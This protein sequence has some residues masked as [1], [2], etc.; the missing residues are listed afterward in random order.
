MLATA[1]ERFTEVITELRSIKQDM[2]NDSDRK[3]NKSEKDK[4]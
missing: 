2:N 3:R 4:S 1:Q